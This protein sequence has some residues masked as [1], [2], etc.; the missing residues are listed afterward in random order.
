MLEVNTKKSI[1]EYNKAPG[2]RVKQATTVSVL[3]GVCFIENVAWRRLASHLATP[4]SPQPCGVIVTDRYDHATIEQRSNNK[5]VKNSWLCFCLHELCSRLGWSQVTDP[6]TAD[7]RCCLPMFVFLLCQR[8]KDVL[9]NKYVNN[10]RKTLLKVHLL[11]LMPPLEWRSP[12]EWILFPCNG[13]YIASLM[14]CW[15]DIKP[16]LLCPQGASGISVHQIFFPSNLF[17]PSSLHGTCAHLCCWWGK[18]A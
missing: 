6:A 8:L 3:L 17:L 12:P 1:L 14:V 2:D 11:F 7:P 18:R 4:S 10:K 13:G 9:V 16:D 5:E 15:A